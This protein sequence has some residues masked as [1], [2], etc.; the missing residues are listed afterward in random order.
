[1]N[2][3]IPNPDEFLKR[4]S[5]DFF[6]QCLAED[7]RQNEYFHGKKYSVASFVMHDYPDTGYSIARILVLEKCCDN[8]FRNPRILDIPF[9]YLH[10]NFKN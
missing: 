4:E 9:F 7:K 8:L 2:K 10:R 3:S 6:R 1:M 5:A